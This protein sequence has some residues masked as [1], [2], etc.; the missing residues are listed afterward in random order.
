MQFSVAADTTILGDSF[1]VAAPPVDVGYSTEDVKTTDLDITKGIFGK[2]T[3]VSFNLSGNSATNLACST[4]NPTLEDVDFALSVFHEFHVDGSG[5][6]SAGQYG[7]SEALTSC[8]SENS[9]VQVCKQTE[10]TPLTVIL[11]GQ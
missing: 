10:T 9:N 4:Q 8:I 7:Q 5:V 1:A 2:V 3:S 6:Y 11:Q